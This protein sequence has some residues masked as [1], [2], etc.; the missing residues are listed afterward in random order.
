MKRRREVTIEIER[1]IVI[2]NHPSN[3]TWCTG[4]GDQVEMLNTNEAA[5]LMGSSEDDI[6][7]LV[8]SA[9]IH[10]TTSADGGVLVCPDSLLNRRSKIQTGP[11]VQRLI[12]SGE[13]EFD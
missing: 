13:I 11:I 2:R 7:A 3:R 10:F 12:S 6:F 9:E 5:H 4:C 8:D 1:E